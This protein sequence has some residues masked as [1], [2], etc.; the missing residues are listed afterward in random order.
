[1]CG[2]CGKLY[3]DPGRAAEPN[4]LAEMCATIRHRGPDDTGAYIQGPVALGST[5]LAI[6]DV[7]AGH[8][9]LCNEDGTVWIAY[10]GETYNF[11]ELRARLEARGHRFR[12]RSDT[13]TIVHLYEEEG[14]NFARHLNG[15]F[16]LALW[17]ARKKLLILARD[18]VGIKPLFYAQLPDRLLFGSE[19]KT[20]LADGIDRQVDRVA[21]H[22]YLSLNYVPGPRTMFKGIHKLQPGH[23]LTASLADGMVRV[24][25][26]WTYPHREEP[27]AASR[28]IHQL[29]G[30]LLEILREV[31]RDT[32]VSDVPVG[33]FLSGGIDSSLVVALMSEVAKQPVRTFS[34]GF[35]E[36]SYNE[37]PYANLVARRF[38]TDHHVLVMDARAEDL[39]HAMADFFDEPFADNSALATYAVSQL[40]AEHVKVVLSGDGGDEVFGGYNTYQADQLARAYRRL[41]GFVTE[42]LVPQLVRRIPPSFTKNS[43]EFRLKRFVQGAAR[44]PL[45]AH[46]SWK[47]YLDEAMKMHL[48]NRESLNGDLESLRP[49]VSLFRECFEECSS[50]DV[51]NRLIYLDNR[52]QLV[53]DMLTKVDR[54]SMAHSL[55]VRVPLLDQRVIQFM[56]KL[57]SRFKLRGFTLKYL[58]KR[59]AKRVLPREILHRP[60]GGFGIP[61][62]DWVS[63]DLRELVS[64]YLSPET[65][66]AHGLFDP[67]AVQAM[68][69]AHWRKEEN[70]SRS[71]WTLLMF[72]LWVERYLQGGKSALPTSPEKVRLVNVG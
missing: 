32:M 7:A 59:M 62:A 3:F 71:I 4:I 28:S 12:T 68:L 65:V 23:I 14:E 45:Y 38:H 18:Q 21:L 13:E 30:E 43:I 36:E 37:L 34:I 48:Y 66:K 54:M 11:Q 5:R 64:T 9:P 2:I 53:D 44:D 20:I 39:V 58:V 57:P 35:Q 8:M 69:S 67:R 49:T 26:Y 51:L 72:S 15:M 25:P 17:D 27:Q 63:G 1:M 33:A 29:E 6:I 52:I 31:T 10:N 55:E 50:P 46:F 56:A 22:D 41:P 16:A 19:I 24:R 42:G 61:L 40:A 70:F 47:A 60:K